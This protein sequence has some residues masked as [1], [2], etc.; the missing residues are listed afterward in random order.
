MTAAAGTAR[1]RLDK[2]L[3]AARFFRTRA[4][5]A[6]ACE[7]NRIRLNGSP[8]KPAHEVRVGDWLLVSS[9]GGEF[10]LKVEGVSNLR[11]P[12]SLAQALYAETEASRAERQR[13]V[14]QRRLA[15]DPEARRAG[16]P[17]KRERR[18]LDQFRDEPPPRLD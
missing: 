14:E 6:Q 18:E 7:R 16:R 2:W 10:E 3:W 17:T 11:G 15:P 8:V 1:V 4:L 13:L 5:A 12:A 9:P